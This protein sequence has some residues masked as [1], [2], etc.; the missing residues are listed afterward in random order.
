MVNF[1]HI[2]RFECVN[3]FLNILTALVKHLFVQ[4]RF[5]FVCALL[6]KANPSID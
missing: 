4:R 5:V 1:K 2:V 3:V 6:H